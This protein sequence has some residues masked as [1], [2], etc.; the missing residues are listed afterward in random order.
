MDCQA[1]TLFG[2]QDQVLLIGCECKMRDAHGHW[3]LDLGLEGPDFA[4]AIL[5]GFEC[6][7]Y[8]FG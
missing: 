6:L 8:G 5:V 2:G 1:A 3:Y 4:V 7:S